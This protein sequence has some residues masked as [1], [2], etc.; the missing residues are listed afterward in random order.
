MENQHHAIFR[1]VFTMELSKR[2]MARLTMAMLVITRGYKYI[3][4]S[5]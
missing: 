3:V 4:A 5:G 1:T 2:A